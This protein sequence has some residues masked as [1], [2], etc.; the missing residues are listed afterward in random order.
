VII[1]YNVFVYLNIFEGANEINNTIKTIVISPLEGTPPEWLNIQKIKLIDVEGNNMA[2]TAT[3][4][5]GRWPHD[6]GGYILDTTELYRKD[7]S[8]FSMFHS[9]G[10]SCTLTITITD[11]SKILSRITIS[12]RRN[13][14][15]NRFKHYKMNL[16]NASGINIIETKLDAANLFDANKQ[17]T[18]TF[19]IPVNNSINTS[20]KTGNNLQ[21]Q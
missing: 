4:T 7:N 21:S 5:N 13:C 1:G 19:D 17:Y 10:T 20:T 6:Y 16:K 11:P 3:S 2:Y 12:N 18:H 15:Q 8:E 14:C 9:G